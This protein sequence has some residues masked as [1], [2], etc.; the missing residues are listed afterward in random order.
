MGWREDRPPG[1]TM[2]SE[3]RLSQVAGAYHEWKPAPRLRWYVRCVWTNMLRPS[4]TPLLVAPDGSIDIIW[5]GEALRIAGPDTRPIIE[6][7]PIGAHVVGIR[8]WPGAARPWLGV[9]ASAL[10]NLRLPLEELWG[11]E[12]AH[13]TERLFEAKRASET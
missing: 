6:D 1:A 3:P 7:V 11:T 10:E 5:T 9:S 13:L 12:A 4:A 2:S 8:F